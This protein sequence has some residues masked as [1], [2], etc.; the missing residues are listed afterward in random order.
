[1][2]QPLR[3][4]IQTFVDA[5]GDA[6]GFAATPLKGV[7][8]IRVFTSTALVRS[9]Y[10]PLVCLVL[11]GAKQVTVGPQTY[12]FSSGR[13]AIVLADV[14]AISRITQA[15][16]H[17]PYLAMAIDLDLSLITELASQMNLAGSRSEAASPVHVDETDAAA[18]DCAV[19]L[20]RLLDRPE[21]I[22]VLQPSIARELHYWLL[23]GRHGHALRSLAAPD[24]T[25]HR[26]ACAVALLRDQFERPL[27]VAQ[28]AAAAGMSP[29]S[30]HYHFRSVTSL[31][32]VQ[33]QKQ[34]RLIEARRR[35]LSE[36]IAAN[37]AAFEVGYES[38]S[39]FTRE[40][41]R[42]FGRPPR[43]DATASRAA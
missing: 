41:A 31:S 6:N 12:T 18:L 8:V 25:A 42:L 23:A 37:Q 43:R 24:G 28:L 20:M 35:L 36:G 29:S 1:M 34:L 27:R 21:A 32:P 33:F 13:S 5:R 39:Q 22:P 2:T 30:F 19:R 9:I 10:K 3:N 38:V 7:G 40:Y 14:P 11:Q 17:E 16:R 4:A 26:I 15:S